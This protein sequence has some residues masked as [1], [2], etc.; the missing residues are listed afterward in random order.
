MGKAG[1][2]GEKLKPKRREAENEYIRNIALGTRAVFV[3]VEV[4]IGAFACVALADILLGLN[5]G[6]TW[7]D[8]WFFGG[9]MAFGGV[10]YL[11]CQGIFRF[12]TANY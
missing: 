12:V 2:V 5:Q 6:H 10:L 4:V 1:N 9:M 8:V 7:Q 11:V 3:L